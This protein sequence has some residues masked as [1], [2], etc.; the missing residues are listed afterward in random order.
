MGIAINSAMD[1]AYNFQITLQKAEGVNGKNSY[2]LA[3]KAFRALLADGMTS[4]QQAY[5]IVHKKIVGEL[6]AIAKSEADAV[7]AVTSS[8]W[9]MGPAT[10]GMQAAAATR[11]LQVQGLANAIGRKIQAMDAAGNAP[12]VNVIIEDHSYGGFETTQSIPASTAA[13]GAKVVWPLD[14]A[15]PQQ[16]Q[17]S[18]EENGIPTTNFESSRNRNNRSPTLRPMGDAT[19]FSKKR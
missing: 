7:A 6:E 5:D 19:S 15:S 12:D 1:A 10:P 16:W 14:L 13:A 4:P 8:A 11:A 3:M 2:Q 17:A 9:D 18:D